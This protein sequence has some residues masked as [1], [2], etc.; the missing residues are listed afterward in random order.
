ML[1]YLDN[2]I[3]E[4]KINKDDI[5]IV[6]SFVMECA[7]IRKAN[8]I[9]IILRENIRKQSGFAFDKAIKVNDKVEIVSYGWATFIGITDDELITNSNYHNYFADYKI[10]NL[11]L[12]KQKKI[13]SKR[14]KDIQDLKKLGVPFPTIM[15][16]H[17]LSILGRL[18]YKL[19]SSINN[20]PPPIR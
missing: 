4:Q 10:A 15:T 12:V 1:E 20:T 9:D 17:F 2:F 3:K 13:H 16:L 11:E 6:G 7:G 8:D 14:K 18:K 5:C 19:K